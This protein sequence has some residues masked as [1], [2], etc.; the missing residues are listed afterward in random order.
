MVITHRPG[1]ML[2]TARTLLGVFRRR[3]TFVF[4]HQYYLAISWRLSSRTSAESLELLSD[5]TNEVGNCKK[6]SPLTGYVRDSEPGVTD[7]MIRSMLVGADSIPLPV[8]FHTS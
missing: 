8:M 2:V 7:I 6:K 1:K 4:R 3:E 5:Y